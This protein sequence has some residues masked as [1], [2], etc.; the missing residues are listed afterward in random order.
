MCNF[1]RE[2]ITPSVDF[3]AEIIYQIAIDIELVLV[4]FN[5]VVMFLKSNLELFTMVFIHQ[6]LLG[7]GDLCR[8]EES[9]VFEQSLLQTI[10]YLL[11]L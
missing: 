1:T 9:L 2:R 8:F 11:S 10:V 6:L 4:F 7:V 5:I 3:L